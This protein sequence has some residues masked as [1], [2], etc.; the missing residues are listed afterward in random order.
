[1]ATASTILALADAIRQTFPE[2]GGRVIAVSEADVT[3]ENVPTLPLAMVALQRETA[4]DNVKSN[5]AIEIVEDILLEVWQRP[6]KY[7]R[8]DGGQSPF[9][10]FYDYNRLRDSLLILLRT[11]RSP[12][13][14][15]VEYVGMETD[16]TDF[17]VILTFQ[18]RHAFKWCADPTE[19]PDPLA[20][21]T[22]DFRVEIA[23]G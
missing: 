13:G 10:A 2:L 15:R 14:Y 21:T 4:V 9:W 5:T 19:T 6:E 22:T 23:P 11:W 8:E 20:C 16:A 17:A 7:R 3:R 12:A 1:M 18:L